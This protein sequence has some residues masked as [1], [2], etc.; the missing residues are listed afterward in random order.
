MITKELEIFQRCFNS[1]KN[2][3]K[4]NDKHIRIWISARSNMEFFGIDKNNLQ[5]LFKQLGI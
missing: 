4:Y 2:S 5:E 1:L 3:K